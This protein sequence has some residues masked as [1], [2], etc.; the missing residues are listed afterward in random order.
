[1]FV[2]SD[3]LNTG[4]YQSWSVENDEGEI[5]AQNAASKQFS[6]VKNMMGSQKVK[7]ACFLILGN[8]VWLRGW[9]KSEA[10]KGKDLMTEIIG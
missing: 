3:L 10:K 1:M 7:T 6:E 5:A 9:R 4:L 8:L 2:L